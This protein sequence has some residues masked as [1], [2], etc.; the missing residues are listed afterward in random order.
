[1]YAHLTSALPCKPPHHASLIT[2]QQS[3][4][5]HISCIACIIYEVLFINYLLLKMCRMQRTKTHPHTHQNSTL[6]DYHSPNSTIAHLA[7]SSPHPTAPLRSSSTLLHSTI[8]SQGRP[9]NTAAAATSRMRSQDSAHVHSPHLFPDPCMSFTH[10]KD[11]KS[12]TRPLVHLANILFSPTTCLILIS[13]IGHNCGL[14]LGLLPNDSKLLS[15]FL[16]SSQI[17]KTRH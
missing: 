11:I 5:C 15:M 14:I 3:S 17:R 9:P 13:V 4:A 10:L 6:S 16:V 2:H 1:M 12:L 7:P 8:L